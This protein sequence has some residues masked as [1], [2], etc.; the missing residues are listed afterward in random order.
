MW[1]KFLL[2]E[3][4]KKLGFTQSKYDDCVLWRGK[5]IMAIYTD[6]TIFTGPDPK[7]LDKIIRKI[8]KVFDIT[9]ELEVTDFLDRKS[10]RLNSSHDLASRMPSSA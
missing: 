5:N 7:E 9:S 2:E 6:D 10:T 8:G 1:N 4:T 3:L